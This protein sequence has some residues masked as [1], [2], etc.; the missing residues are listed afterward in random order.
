MKRRDRNKEI[1]L[2]IEEY[3]KKLSRMGKRQFAEEWNRTMLQLNP[4][5]EIKERIDENGEEW[6]KTPYER[7]R[8]AVYA[9]GNKW[10]KENFND[11][12]G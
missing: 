9:T 11:T 10:A 4:D 6:E 2:Q 12:H 7:T 3:R 5:S 1:R 8:D